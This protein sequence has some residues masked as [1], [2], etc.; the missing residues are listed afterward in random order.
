MTVREVLKGVT[1]DVVSNWQVTEVFRAVNGALLGVMFGVESEDGVSI[2]FALSEDTIRNNKVL[3]D[4]F[5]SLIKAMGASDVKKL[6]HA[7]HAVYARVSDMIDERDSLFDWCLEPELIKQ[8]YA[9]SLDGCRFHIKD[10][11]VFDLVPNIF[12]ALEV[13]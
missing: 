11:I 2:R 1:S 6:E 8:G 10:S 9:F 12:N 7:G 5:G 13:S 3:Y 4:E